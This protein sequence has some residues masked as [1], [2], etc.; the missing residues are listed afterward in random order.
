MLWV[1]LEH[2]HFDR[3]ISA[4]LIKRFVD[5]DAR[6]TFVPRQHQEKERPQ[7]AKP[8][9]IPNTEL[10]AHDADGTTFHKILNKYDLHDQVLRTM[11]GVVT[12]VVEYVFKNG[13]PD[14]GFPGE[15][16]LGVLCMAEGAVLA[17]KSDAETIERCLFTYDAL[18]SVFQAKAF[19]KARGEEKGATMTPGM[20]QAI[21]TVV[22]A[23]DLRQQGKHLGLGTLVEVSD[24]FALALVRFRGH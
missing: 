6:F 11:D 3:V 23:T 7:D 18:Y 12:E 1:T 22:I 10:S 16:A 21:A 17:C 19:L 2:V 8:F 9:G 15:I 4:W 13:I 20:W 24:E 14:A 5:V